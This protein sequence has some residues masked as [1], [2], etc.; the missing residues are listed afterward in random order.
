MVTYPGLPGP[1]IGEH[2]T[3]RDSRAHYAPGTEFSIGRVAMVGNTGT[4]LDSPFHRFADGADL[5]GLPLSRMTDLDGVVVR[6]TGAAS[7]AF[8]RLTLLPHD[9]AGRA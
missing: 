2:L 8:D 1:E 7:R 9:V 4:Y 5:A 6:V 3:R